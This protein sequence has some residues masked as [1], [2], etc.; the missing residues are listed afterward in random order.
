M[1]KGT[2]TALIIVGS[3]LAV[4][5]ILAIILGSINSYGWVTMGPG[6][7]S[8]YGGTW[9]MG[10]IMLIILGLIIWGIIAL[11][12]HYNRAP[13]NTTYNY[14]ALEILKIRYAKGEINKE[15]FEEKKKALL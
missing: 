3:V 10:I 9:Y 2:K 1:G 14:S 12:S 13:Q 15:E 8:G 6:M 4:L 7:M 5:I 11:I